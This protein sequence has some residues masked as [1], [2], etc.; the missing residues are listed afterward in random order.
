[1]IYGSAVAS[2]CVEGIG[3]DGLL[4]V[5]RTTIDDRYQQFRR[6]AHFE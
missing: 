3:T 2:C 4:D 6:L 5:Q 1:M